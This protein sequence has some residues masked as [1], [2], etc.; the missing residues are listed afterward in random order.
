MIY[1]VVG[2]EVEKRKAA[3]EN[4]L[5]HKNPSFYVRKETLF[6]VP[7][8]IDAEDLF[9]E[10]VIVMLEQV[11]T[12]AE[13][14][15]YIKKIIAEMK[16]SRNMFI[17]DEPFVDASFI[18]TFEKH[19]EAVFDARESK[20]KKGFPTAFL[21]AFEKKDKKTA[22]I[23][24][25]KL[26]NE[27]AELTHGALWWKMKTMWQGSQG[28]RSSVY[29]KEELSRIGYALI[30]ASHKAHA[31]AADLKGEMEKIVLSL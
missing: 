15:E 12:G 16:A 19:A 2:T 6:Q 18:K 9:G 5:G 17:F 23:E 24:W 26:R 8:L 11:G 7:A 1:A 4:I 29:S 31:G 3:F 14:R 25:M 22:W 27:E 20:E 21:N 30:S 13:G 10:Q 28:G